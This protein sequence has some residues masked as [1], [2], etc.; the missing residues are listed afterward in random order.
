MT[1]GDLDEADR[2][3]RLAF[4]TFL[5]LPDPMKF[6]GD[7]DY[8]Y[9][10]Y[11]ADP[12]AALTAEINGRVVGSNFALDWGSVG[13][14][15]PLTIHPDYWD[16]GVAR[17]L[18]DHTMKIFDGWGTK[19]IGIF[20]F[21]QSAKHIHLYQKYGLWPRYLTAVMSKEVEKMADS[22]VVDEIN[23]SS[24]SS[25]DQ[26]E[27]LQECAS[28]TNSIYPGLNLKKEIISVADQKLGDT[29]MLRQAGRL[30][31]MAICHCGPR[32]E[33]GSGTCY[34]KFA[35]VRPSPDSAEIFDSLLY[36]CERY[37]KSL[38]ATRLVG[39][40]NMGRH[41]AYR[42]MIDRGF[43]TD[44]QGVAMQKP[45]EPGYNREEIFLI[46]DWR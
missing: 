20:T 1:E 28:L 25:E 4:G 14:F 8:V 3:V 23:Y 37:A 41:S 2:I 24:L 35:A 15:G 42:R 17:A 21:A 34:V 36:A 40:V 44:M 43:R 33:A 18:L 7:A 38:H 13:V 45:N 26:K 39:G 11:H 27:A 9:T 29:V 30:Q 16:H 46:D 6:M 10:R 5:G 32:T 31:A 22:S 19:H 12:P